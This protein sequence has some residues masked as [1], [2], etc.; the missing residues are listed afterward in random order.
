M[1]LK[2]TILSVLGRDALRT[3]VDVLE[4]EDVDRRSVEDMASSLVTPVGEAEMSLE[5]EAAN[6]KRKRE[7]LI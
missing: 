3:V 6:K 7:R 4:M 2:K 5:M 1:N